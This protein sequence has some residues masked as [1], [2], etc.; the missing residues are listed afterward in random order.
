MK[1]IYW[2][3]ALGPALLRM[4]VAAPSGSSKDGASEP[5]GHIV[6][7]KQE[8]ESKHVDRHLD[9]VNG[10]HKGL[11]SRDDADQGHGIEHTYRA[12]DIDFHGY[13][14]K[15]S[16]EVLEKIKRHEHVDFVEE[17]GVHSLGER[18]AETPDDKPSDDGSNEQ[19]SDDGNNKQPGKASTPTEI[20]GNQNQNEAVGL[21]TIGQGYNTFLDKGRIVDAVIWPKN[22]KRAETDG[23]AAPAGNESTQV[24]TLFKWTPPTTD[25]D[26]LIDLDLE[27][28]FEQPNLKEINDRVIAELKVLK[29]ERKKQEQDKDNALAT[30]EIETRAEKQN[31]PGTLRKEYKLTEDFSSYLKTLDIGGGATISGWGQSASVSGNYLNQAKFAQNTLTYVAFLDVEKQKTQPGGFQIN[32]ARY[33]AGQFA[34]DFGDRWIH[35]FKTGGK[36]IA[37]LTFTSKDGTK[38]SDLKAHA[39]ASLGF[40]GVKGELSLDVKK[41]MEEVSKRSSVEVSFFYEGALGIFMEK[42][43]KAPGNIP[44]GSA[45]A[46]LG[47]VKQWA[48]KFQSHACEHTFAYG[49][50]LDEYATVPGFRDLDANIKAPNYDTALLYAHEILRLMVKIEEQKNFLLSG[51]TLAEDKKFPVTTDAIEMIDA[52]KKWVENAELNPENVKAPANELIKLLNDGFI[53]KYK[54]DVIKEQQKNTPQGMAEC[55]DRKVAAIKECLAKAGSGKTLEDVLNCKDDG[56]DAFY[57]C[58]KGLE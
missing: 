55:R 33:K 16:D 2:P 23:A 15:F 24:E 21:L 40:W 54:A 57:R 38:T 12:H 5:L 22:K 6:V 37:R 39:D 41:G 14:G 46:V 8:L 20:V 3:L 11:N 34:R 18:Q 58:K 17:D 43:E 13:S 48:D 10:M 19:P 53:K 4:A 1:A 51:K 9:W 52:C 25:M 30:N 29:E 32:Q 36:M 45:E 42:D 47:Q 26:D 35:G 44:S 28:Y 31:C 49:P 27:E 56:A 7:L 50:L